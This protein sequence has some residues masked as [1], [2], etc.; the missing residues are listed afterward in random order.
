MKKDAKTKTVSC[1]WRISLAANFDITRLG[2]SLLREYLNLKKDFHKAQVIKQK[3]SN[4]NKT[5]N[6]VRT[7]NTVALLVITVKTDD[8]V[9]T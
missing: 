6:S 1:T 2:E 9:L 5:I 4:I 3:N 7:I 8:T